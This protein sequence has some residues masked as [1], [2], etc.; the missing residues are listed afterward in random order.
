[1]VC[2]ASTGWAALSTRITPPQRYA[3]TLGGSGVSSQETHQ[4]AQNRSAPA[5]RKL[6]LRLALLRAGLFLLHLLVGGGLLVVRGDGLVLLPEAI[7]AARGV[8][9]L[10][11]AGEE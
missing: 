4:R 11:L 3:R 1:M 8:H 9:Q 6:R 2:L 10:V 5:R 7:H